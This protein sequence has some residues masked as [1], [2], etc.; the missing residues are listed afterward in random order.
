[1]PEDFLMEPLE[2]ELTITPE[3]I[4]LIQ[5]QQQQFLQQQQLQQQ[6]LQQP[7]QSLSTSQQREEQKLWKKMFGGSNT[8][9]SNNRISTSPNIIP[10]SKASEKQPL[11]GLSSSSTNTKSWF[12]RNQSKSAPTSRIQDSDSESS[13]SDS[14]SQSDLGKVLSGKNGGGGPSNAKFGGQF[15][16][17]SSASS[18]SSLFRNAS[19][20]NLVGRRS[21]DKIAKPDVVM[22]DAD[23][24]A[25]SHYLSDAASDTSNSN[26]NPKAS[27][28]SL[29]AKL[30]SLA[31]NMAPKAIVSKIL[32][33]TPSPPAAL[34]PSPVPHNWLYF[35]LNR[36]I[37]I[38]RA[39]TAPHKQLHK[40]RQLS[41]KR[42][43]NIDRPP[44]RP[45][46]SDTRNNNTPPDDE[47]T[48]H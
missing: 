7:Q 45:A 6:L 3:Q 24:E 16:G 12:S 33:S 10:S 48:K 20:T 37:N 5:Q 35:S 18:A 31:L 42:H 39:T 32:H 46:I 22:S 2:M 36:I 13:D 1:M 27:V 38:S 28:S 11:S 40:H 34:P 26:N 8:S 9:H 14:E 25:A 43:H 30:S 29:K 4:L 47:S 41:Q 15:G 44:P 21:T 17:V 23:D 19:A